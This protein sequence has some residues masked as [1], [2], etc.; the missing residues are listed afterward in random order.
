MAKTYCLKSCAECQL[1]EQLNCPGCYQGPG[2]RFRGDCALKKCCVGRGHETCE[3]CNQNSYCGTFR[4]RERMPEIRLKE[5]EAERQRREILAQRSPILGKWLTVLFWLMIAAMV[6]GLMLEENIVKWLPGLRI[7]G[8]V[9]RSIC[10]AAQCAILLKL[11]KLHQG[12]K[13]AAIC[14]LV[15]QAAQLATDQLVDQSML[16]VQLLVT[17][18]ISTIGLVSTYYEYITHSSMLVGMDGD[19]A[20]Q[21]EK[22]WKWT[23][24]LTLGSLGCIVLTAIAPLLGILVLLAVAIGTVVV[25]IIRYVYLYRTAKIFRNYGREEED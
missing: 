3:T 18:P 24:G 20:A 16:G 2:E 11:S 12:Y 19:Q 15:A 21:W 23:I 4:G 14:G 7:P 17:I 25:G 6:P 1:K 8:I 10:I 13:I 22:L 9:L 5:Q